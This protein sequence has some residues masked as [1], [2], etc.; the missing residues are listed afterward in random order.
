MGLRICCPSYFFNQASDTIT[1][2]PATPTVVISVPVITTLPNERVKIDAMVETV[3]RAL[4]QA[5]QWGFT[6]AF[7]LRR[8]ATVLTS[9]NYG[10]RGNMKF[11]GELGSVIDA[12]TLTW[13]DVPLLPGTYL[14]NIEVTRGDETQEDNIDFEI[15]LDRS[16]NAIV[17][18]Q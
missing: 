3:V 8:D 13:T 11:V 4:E 16:I 6:I 17:F 15:V 1:L 12:I 18:H 7:N 5:S 2:L 10:E 9:V 14:Y